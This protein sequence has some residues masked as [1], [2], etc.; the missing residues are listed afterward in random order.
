MKS[1]DIPPISSKLNCVKTY[2]T[3]NV[4]MPMSTSKNTRLM[5]AL[6]RISGLRN[7]CSM[8]FSGAKYW[9]ADPTSPAYSMAGWDLVAR[10]SRA[11]TGMVSSAGTW[12]NH[13]WRTREPDR[14]R[15]IE[16]ILSRNDRDRQRMST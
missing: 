16:I 5:T 15:R 14:N 7:W 13:V 9:S 2:P 4:T 8:G 1:K 3:N 11:G 10:G 6:G 12:G